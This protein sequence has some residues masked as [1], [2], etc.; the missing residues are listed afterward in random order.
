MKCISDQKMLPGL[1]HLSADKL[2]GRP[3]KTIFIIAKQGFLPLSVRLFLLLSLL[4]AQFI[5]SS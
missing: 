5:F 4:I 1:V 2:P 3:S